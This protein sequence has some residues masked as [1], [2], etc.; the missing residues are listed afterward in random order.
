MN[1]GA[2]T[3]PMALRGSRTRYASREPMKAEL[4]A[5]VQREVL[6]P[7]MPATPSAEPTVTMPT[8][9]Q[10]EIPNLPINKSIG[11]SLD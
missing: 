10:T 3:I 6:I 11:G 4:A 1:A 9:S 5:K 2:L 7:G 8:Q